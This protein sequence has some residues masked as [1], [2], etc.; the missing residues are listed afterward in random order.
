MGINPTT[1]IFEMYQFQSKLQVVGEDFYEKN[2]KCLDR[3]DF[4][5]KA[6]EKYLLRQEKCVPIYTKNSG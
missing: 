4:E 3:G 2:S 1:S 5:M 6:L